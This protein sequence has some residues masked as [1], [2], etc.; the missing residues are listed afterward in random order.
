MIVNFIDSP[1]YVQSYTINNNVA[2]QS[3]TI[4]GQ[5]LCAISIQPDFQDIATNDTFSL[6]CNVLRNIDATVRFSSDVTGFDFTP[7]PLQQGQNG[8]VFT[9]QNAIEDDS[10]TYG[11]SAVSAIGGLQTQVGSVV[12]VMGK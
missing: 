9:R 11:C 2:S 5:F 12:V 10:G 7:S 6:L 8:L 3:A 4:M 1:C